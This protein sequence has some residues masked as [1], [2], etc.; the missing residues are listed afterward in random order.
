MAAGQRFQLGSTL[1][2]HSS[3]RPRASVTWCRRKLVCGFIFM[4]SNTEGAEALAARAKVSLARIAHRGP[5]D[6]GLLQRGRTVIG[7][8]RLSII[9]LATSRQPMSDPSGRY[10]FAYNGEVYN[11]RQL[12]AELETKWDFRT[13]GDTEVA[14]AGL[15]RYGADFLQRMEGMWALCLWDSESDTLLLSRDRMGKKP[16]Y[17]CATSNRMA[18]ASELS[19]LAA[20]ANRP[21][22]EDLDSTADYLR[23]GF[24]LPGR[25][26]YLGVHEVLPG[27]WLTWQPGARPNSQAYWSLKAV[28]CPSFKQEA[29]ELVRGSFETAV[30]RRLEADVEVGAF[31]SGGVDSSL[32]VAVTRKRLG[33]NIK[34]FSIGFEDPS[35]DERRFA[36]LAAR[37]CGTEHHDQVVTEWDRSS[38]ERLVLRHVGQPFSDPSLLPT[39]AVSSLASQYVK[40]ALSGDGGDE[41]FSGYQR[42]QARV[43]LRWYTR[44]PKA[45]RI[46]ADR[47][48]SGLPE[49]TA[50][51]SHS[52]LKK[53]H[54][55]L[56]VIRRQDMETPYVAPVLYSR[57]AFAGLAPDL[58]GLGHPP[59]GIPTVCDHHD[60]DRMMAADTL[61]YLPQDI[62]V[63]VDRASMA[64]SLEVRAPFLDRE[65]V[66]LAFSVPAS[67]HRYRFA[68]KRLL[69][70]AIADLLPREIWRRRKQGFA[71][72]LGL[73]MRGSLGQALEDLLACTQTVLDPAPVKELLEHHRLGRRDHGHRLWSLY[74]YLLW[75]SHKGQPAY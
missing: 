66:E 7:H 69:R 47:A 30:A 20:L 52:L 14:L 16:L 34:T 13:T 3:L 17:Y 36:R 31:L 57:D 9:D 1:L 19:A 45:L 53:A 64:H 25:T 27:H 43:L 24:C 15:V 75:K 2:P 41:L 11:Y 62:L 38:L 39:A 61:I 60:L 46:A 26:A 65:L 42:Y 35:Y 54:L 4:T 10:V 72:P 29:L 59:P 67:R 22:Q 74:V 23:Y 49:P 12:R 37:D 50:H 28:G 6:E 56:D 32:V 21:W 58:A 55:F 68:G 8:R 70:S 5:D 51:H 63:K 71:V 73:W 40:V 18:C 48:I 33:V 44:L